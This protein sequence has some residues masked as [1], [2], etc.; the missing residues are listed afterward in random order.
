MVRVTKV[1]R[2]PVQAKNDMFTC[3]IDR[4]EDPSEIFDLDEIEICDHNGRRLL[5]FDM[6]DNDNNLGC[7]IMMPNKFYV[8]KGVK[9]D[10]KL[11]K[12]AAQKVD[13]LISLFTST[14][15]AKGTI[16]CYTAIATTNDLQG[17]WNEILAASKTFV[18]VKTF[19]NKSTG[20]TIHL[21]VSNN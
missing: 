14:K 5:A 8:A 4:L 16:K 6:D 21:W 13:K 19:V 17:F 11:K 10:E 9:N 2:K 3:N 15:D 1:V 18:K 20:R 7:S 12:F